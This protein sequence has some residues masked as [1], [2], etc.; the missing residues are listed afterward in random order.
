MAR[1]ISATQA[2]LNDPSIAAAQVLS[3]YP[4]SNDE[5]DNA[6]RTCYMLA[7]PVYITVP[8]NIAYAKISS[9]PLLT[10]LD[11]SWP[12]NDPATEAEAVEQIVEMIHKSEKPIVLA[13]AGAIKFRVIVILNSISNA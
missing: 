1:G 6:L 2:I 4:R 11:T 7:K 10:P 3:F 8:T 12:V 5:I 9:R 13:D